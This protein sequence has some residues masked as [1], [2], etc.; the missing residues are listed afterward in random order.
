[1]YFGGDYNPEQWPE[2]V[3]HEDVA[4]MRRAR[5]NLVTLGV[6]AWSS[7]QPAPGRWEFGRLDRVFDLLHDNGIQVDLATPTASPPPWFGRRH[8]DTLTVTADGTRLG[9]G[10][11]DTYCVS[12]PAYRTASRELASVLAERYGG[13]PALAMWHVH[14]EY[15][16]WCHCDHVA[17]AFRT[18]LRARHGDLATLNERWT[19]AF[20]S[21]GYSD[22]DE[23]QPP[24]ATQWLPNPSQ[25]LDFRRFLSDEMLAHFTEQR[26]LLRP[27]GKPVTTNF[28]FGAWVP[29]DHW[30]WAREVDL[31]AVDDY[32]TGDLAEESAFTADLAR[33]W[34]GGKPWILMEQAAAVEYTPRRTL[35]RPP[36]DLART[37]LIHVERGSIGAMFFQW[38]ASRGGAEQ[39]FHG[40]VPHAGPDT[41]TFR[42]ITALGETLAALPSPARRTPEVAIVWDDEAWWALQGRGLPSQD[43]DYLDAVKQPHRLLYRAGHHVAFVHPEHD[44]SPFRLVIVPSLLPVTDAALANL[45][46]C[47][48]TVLMSY[49]SAV[50]DE[51]LRVRLGGRLPAFGITIREH[52]PLAG[53]LTL[54]DGT[55]AS[56]WSE[57]IALDG[58]EAVVAYPDGTPAITRFGKA[59]YLSTRLA[60]KGYEKL[61]TCLLHPSYCPT[62]TYVER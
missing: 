5:V 7:L 43:L 14:N 53:P 56:L 44:L 3:W 61:L 9:H 37:T 49:F 21:Q 59:W 10:S 15:G 32:P 1:M 31:L 30:K 34:A 60:D 52:R 22:W 46:A 16:T 25:L 11:R 2:H 28:A 40:M 41:R 33:S 24:R 8:P 38:R 48:G 20:W 19:T 54:S 29:V 26:D 36:G 45:A 42:E 57:E 58:A 50:T 12:A 13:H 35:P 6:F 27:T 4:L 23:I 17:R 62:G 55:E 18:W 39:W 51:H 47:E